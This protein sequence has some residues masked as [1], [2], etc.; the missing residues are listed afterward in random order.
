MSSEEYIDESVLCDD[1]VDMFAE[2]TEICLVYDV[3]S[4]SELWLRC[5]LCCKCVHDFCTSSDTAEYY[6]C[7]FNIMN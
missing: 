2:D 4:N 7:D 1:I 5:V 6:T 3:F